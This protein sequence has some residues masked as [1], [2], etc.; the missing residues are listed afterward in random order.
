MPTPSETTRAERLPLIGLAAVIAAA[1]LLYL[2][3]LRDAIG[4]FQHTNEGFYGL[5][6]RDYAHGPLLAP[7]L[8]PLESNNPPLYP[9]VQALLVRAGADPVVAGRAISLLATLLCAA[10]VFAL[11][12]RLYDRR[13]GLVAA[14]VFVFLPGVALV[15]RNAQTDVP[16]LALQLAA[17]TVYVIAAERTGRRSAALLGALAG[18]LM[19]AAALTKLSALIALPA[20]ALWQVWRTR[21]LRWLAEPATL[22]ALAAT[23]LVGGTW[24]GYRAATA[25]EFLTAQSRLIGLGNLD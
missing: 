13:T 15:G 6:A 8:H 3:H 16:V 20:L 23:A 14:A 5:L 24:Y 9:W 12:A 19:G 21:G 11:C 17:V 25:A 10:L 22:G 7:W 4:G 1:A 2:P 18:A